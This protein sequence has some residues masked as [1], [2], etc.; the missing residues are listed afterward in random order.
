MKLGI[1]LGSLLLTPIALESS[2]SAPGHE[3]RERITWAP[4]KFPIFSPK[5]EWTKPKVM[6]TSLRAE[7]LLIELE[8]TDIRQTSKRYQAE[9]GR[10][11]DAADFYQ[12]ICFLGGSRERW[13][14]WLGSGEIDGDRVSDFSI[15]RIDSRANVDSK[16]RPLLSVSGEPI[17]SPSKIRIGMSESDLK[18]ALGE[19]T[20]RSGNF[21]YYAHSH[22]LKLHGEPYTL[23]N[24]VT[25][26]VKDGVVTAMKVWKSTQS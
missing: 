15:K 13:A 11:G 18:L 25:V 12:W 26:E 17:T 9:L 4:A 2:Q 24:T 5:K 21:L 3:V 6:V 7:G 10:E 14:L 1:L 20:A 16:C 23:M 8:K 22:D 19:P